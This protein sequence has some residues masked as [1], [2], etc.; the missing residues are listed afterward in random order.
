MERNRQGTASKWTSGLAS[1]ISNIQTNGVLEEEILAGNQ[2]G[3]NP[4]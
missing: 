4:A 3:I 1:A 2:R